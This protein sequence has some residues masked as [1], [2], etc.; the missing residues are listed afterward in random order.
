VLNQEKKKKKKKKN[1]RR[2]PKADE[3]LS[4]LEI[5]EDAGSEVLSEELLSVRKK[6]KRKRKL[7]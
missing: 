4:T 2:E 6:E 5:T 7:E 3:N 1:K